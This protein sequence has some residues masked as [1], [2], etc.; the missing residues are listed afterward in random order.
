MSVY[1]RRNLLFSKQPLV[2]QHTICVVKCGFTEKQS[3]DLRNKLPLNFISYLECVYTDFT[4]AWELG[5]E[6]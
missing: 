5:A 6:S 2:T 1:L 4:N 3:G